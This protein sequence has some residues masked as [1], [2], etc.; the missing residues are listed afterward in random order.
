MIG[1]ALALIAAGALLAGSAR[2]RLGARMDLV[3][4]MFFFVLFMT[5]G[6][7]LLIGLFILGGIGLW[8]LF[9]S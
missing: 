2:W 3:S 8:A 7:L 5:G 1:A 4:A 9:G 6:V